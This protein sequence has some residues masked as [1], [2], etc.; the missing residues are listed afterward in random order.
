[1]AAPKGKRVIR[2]RR[3][4]KNIEKGAVHIRSSFNNTMVTI[5][6]TMEQNTRTLV[7]TDNGPGLV[8][9]MIDKCFDPFV[10]SKAVGSGLGLAIAR[11]LAAQNG[12]FIDLSNSITGGTRA[13]MVQDLSFF[14][15]EKDTQDTT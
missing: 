4:R 13:V 10:T 15:T 6:D 11:R 12:T 7:I 5:T 2:K 3:E 8:P 14:R 1:M 9:E